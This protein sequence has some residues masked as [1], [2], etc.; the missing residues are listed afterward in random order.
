MKFYGKFKSNI[1]KGDYVCFDTFSD[2]LHRVLNLSKDG[3]SVLI[4]DG[5]K[6]SWRWF[7]DVI[8][9]WGVSY[10]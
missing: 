7:A 1:Q 9:V 2:T 3:L 6:L 8:S 10:D 5:K 4:M